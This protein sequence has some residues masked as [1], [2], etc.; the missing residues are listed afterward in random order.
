MRAVLARAAGAVA[1]VPLW[2]VF[3]AIGLPTIVMLAILVPLGQVADEP[4]HAVRVAALADGRLVGRKASSPRP[5][6]SA[7]PAAGFDV[8]PA[9]VLWGDQSRAGEGSWTGQRS[10]VSLG[11]VASYTPTFY[12]PAA[13]GF[14][15]AK[16]AAATPGTALLMGRVASGLAFLALGMLSLSIAV[17][18][19]ALLFAVL[20][21]P[22]TL[23][24]G[25]SLNQD[26]LLVATSV[27]A[28]ACMTRVIAARAEGRAER[29]T[30]AAAA[31]ALAL[32]VAAKPPYLPLVAMLLLPLGRAGW[33]LDGRKLAGRAA[34]AA[35]AVAPAI[36]WLIAVTLDLSVPVERPPYEAGPL[37]PGPRPARFAG[38]DPGAQLRV[39]L[40]Y[41]YRIFTVPW[42][43][44]TSVGRLSRL[45]LAFIGVLGWHD[46]KLGAWLYAAWAGALGVSLWAVLRRPASRP[47]GGPL[48]HPLWHV[49]LVMAAVFGTLW[50][51]L[52]SQYLTWTNVG[53]SAIW[54]PQGRYLL[55][56]APLLALLPPRDG[57]VRVPAADSWAWVPALVALVGMA[58]LYQVVTSAYGG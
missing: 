34:V 27:F 42:R 13:L 4:P 12:A 11:T 44:L 21:V 46:L 37:W 16:A 19:Q 25:A 36:V 53:E 49:A 15:L 29:A 18:G 6:G 50:L 26:G 47:S 1:A 3:A 8:D 54:G 51:I 40:A 17:R 35:L 14:A 23:S 38:T 55:P 58:D 22:M 7:V 43:F 41:P 57:R 56:I 31:L 9:I 2:A 20:A 28:A 24:L 32:V 5:D 30:F 39:L 52:L 48:A 33:G 45:G 10:F